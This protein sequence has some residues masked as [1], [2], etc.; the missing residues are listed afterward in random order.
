MPNSR[1]RLVEAAFALFDERGFE[2]TT[3][4][5]VAE[6]AGVGRST[7]F[8]AFGSKEDVIFPDHAE[9]LRA[10]RD[11]LATATGTTY[12]VAVTEAAR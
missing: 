6:R 2:G 1:D 4:D 12:L 9:V 11:R 7:F 3:V 8:R 5:D 10:M